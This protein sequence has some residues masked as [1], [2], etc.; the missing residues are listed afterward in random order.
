MA[1]QTASIKP[2][3]GSGQILVLAG[4]QLILSDMLRIVAFTAI[5]T[6][7]LALQQISGQGMVEM[8]LAIKP[9]YQF[10]VST[11]VLDMTGGAITVAIQSVKALIV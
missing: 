8:L 6:G 5:Q 1:A 10:A 4:R 11:E 2:E 9:D 7:V 3:K